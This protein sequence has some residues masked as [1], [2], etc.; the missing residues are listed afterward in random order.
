MM[1][2]EAQVVMGVAV[3]SSMHA[4]ARAVVHAI[5]TYLLRT[6]G[7]HRD[8]DSNQVRERYSELI[9]D[10]RMILAAIKS[11]FRSL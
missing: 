1:H 11:G 9:A 8:V 6:R 5:R 7:T 2:V 4:I 3:N 10:R